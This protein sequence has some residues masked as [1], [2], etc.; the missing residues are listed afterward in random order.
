MRD[1]GDY[2]DLYLMTDVLLLAQGFEEFR[3]MEI[4]TYN[5]DLAH[6]ISTASYSLDCALHY[7]KEERD[8][9]FFTDEVSTS[10]RDADSNKGNK[11]KRTNRRDFQTKG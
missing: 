2:T 6:Y 9:F 4:E 11:A 7:L 8:F 3:K 10:R 1:M 5:L